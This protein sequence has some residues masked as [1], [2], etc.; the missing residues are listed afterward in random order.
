MSRCWCIPGVDPF[1]LKRSKGSRGER[2]RRR[3]TPIF[4]LSRE[5]A[6]GG[7]FAMFP[8]L[9][10]LVERS[11][12]VVG[13]TCFLSPAPRSG[14]TGTGGPRGASIRSISASPTPGARQRMDSRQS[15]AEGGYLR[16]EPR[17]KSRCG[18]IY[19][20]GGACREGKG[21]VE[22]LCM[23]VT[24]G[25]RWFVVLDVRKDRQGKGAETVVWTL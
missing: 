14:T 12:V 6:R 3:Q 8:L 5:G 24:G 13:V 22:V 9:T 17:R 15:G 11:P 21:R 23:C 1:V 20:R 19:R 16:S 25:S 7:R 18:R 10:S 2:R 4:S